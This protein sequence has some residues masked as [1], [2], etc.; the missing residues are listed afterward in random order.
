[1]ISI[2]KCVQVA[3]PE[4]ATTSGKRKERATAAK[5]LPR[6]V[7]AHQNPL[8]VSTS[9]RTRPVINK[10]QQALNE[11]RYV[12]LAGG[13]SLDPGL[14]EGAGSGRDYWSDQR[15]GMGD[16]KDASGWL[17]WHL[18]LI[19][20]PTRS[21]AREAGKAIM[22]LGVKTEREPYKDKKG[23]VDWPMGPRSLSEGKRENK[24]EGD[25]RDG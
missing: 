13:V 25:T 3:D 5:S 6:A 2:G 10:L 9:E 14:P 20:S 19:T 8:F 12:R 23:P 11:S 18:T 1:M 15:F 24:E 16:G 17:R 22:Y 21:L 4:H 7:P